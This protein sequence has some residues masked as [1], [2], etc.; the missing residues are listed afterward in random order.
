HSCARASTDGTSEA[1]RIVAIHSRWVGHTEGIIQRIGI[2]IEGLGVGGVV[3]AV[4]GVGGHP[5]ARNTVVLTI[6]RMVRIGFKIC[7]HAS[8][9]II[10]QSTPQIGM[11]SEYQLA[12]P[13]SHTSTGARLNPFRSQPILMLKKCLVAFTKGKSK[14]TKVERRRRRSVPN[15]RRE[16]GNACRWSLR[17][18]KVC[19]I[20]NASIKRTN[21]PKA[22]PIHPLSATAQTHKTKAMNNAIP[23]QKTA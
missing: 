14:C 13:I 4:V 22:N 19:F 8:K 6:L 3:T 20:K 11:I 23:C 9:L 10:V 18:A 7:V 15:H 16:G 5:A 2:A 1:D 12:Y 17:L 21:S